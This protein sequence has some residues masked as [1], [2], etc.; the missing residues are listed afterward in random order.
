M[1]NKIA[2]FCIYGILWTW[3]W[4]GLEWIC[5]RFWGLGPD[6]GPIIPDKIVGFVICSIVSGWIAALIANFLAKYIKNWL[7]LT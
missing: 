3:T 5:W 7:Q 1:R 6:G 4:L 2:A